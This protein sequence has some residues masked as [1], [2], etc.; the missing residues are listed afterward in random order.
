MVRKEVLH[1]GSPTLKKKKKYPNLGNLREHV[2]L[3][4][5]LRGSGEGEGGNNVMSNLDMVVCPYFRPNC[6]KVQNNNI[7]F[8]QVIDQIH[9]NVQSSPVFV[10]TH[11]LMFRKYFNF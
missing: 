10:K 11:Q 7:I 8:V 3:S 9:Q 5:S 2:L 6:A 1:Y 4:H